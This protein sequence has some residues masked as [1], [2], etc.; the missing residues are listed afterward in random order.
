[1]AGCVC[2]ECGVPYETLGLDIVLPDDQWLMIFPDYEEAGGILCGSCIAKRAAMLPHATVIH[3]YIDLAPV[4]PGPQ[5]RIFTA[6]PDVP[7]VQIQGDP[8]PK[9][10]GCDFYCADCCPATP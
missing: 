4:G 7:S 6:T 3:A 9:C 2:G 10:G 1:M 5:A 8:C